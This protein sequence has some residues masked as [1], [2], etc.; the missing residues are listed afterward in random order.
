MSCQIINT[1]NLGI[2]MQQI[3][4][5]IEMGSNLEKIKFKFRF[6]TITNSITYELF[7]LNAQKK[8]SFDV[9]R[10]CSTEMACFNHVCLQ[11]FV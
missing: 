9:L 10:Q 2:V 6:T 3:L 5:C 8:V 7:L 4:I 1:N 11:L